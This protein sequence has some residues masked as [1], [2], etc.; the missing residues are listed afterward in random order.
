[1]RA[2]GASRSQIFGLVTAESLL[3]TGLGSACGILLA[4]AMGRLFENVVKQFVSL[5]PT[6]SLLAMTSAVTLQCLAVGMTVGLLAG[7]YPAWQASRLHPA[8]A[9]KMD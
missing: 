3:L 6:G 9:V 8:D 4:I 1:M 5:A 7:L 2:L